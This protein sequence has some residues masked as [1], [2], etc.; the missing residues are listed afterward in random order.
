MIAYPTRQWDNLPPGAIS[1]IE[2]GKCL[3][4]IIVHPTAKGLSMVIHRGN[5]EQVAETGVTDNVC[6]VLLYF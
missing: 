1:N 4:G 2:M 6:N 3:L 5:M